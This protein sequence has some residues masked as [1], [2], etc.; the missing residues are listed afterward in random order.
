MQILM[1]MKILSNIHLNKYSAEKFD[2]I[3]PDSTSTS[4][5]VTTE[6]H[7]KHAHAYRVIAVFAFEPVDTILLLLVIST[8]QF[9]LAS[10]NT[11]S[12]RYGN[13]RT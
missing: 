13:H 12:V 7:E 5:R 1:K 2:S 11:S 8:L 10:P 4:V 9:G 3:I 6:L